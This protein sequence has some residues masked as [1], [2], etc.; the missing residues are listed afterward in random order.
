MHWATFWGIFPQT[1][2]ATLI[3]TSTPPPPPT[4]VFRKILS[5]LPK[6]GFLARLTCDR[7]LV[8]IMLNETS[9]EK[10]DPTGKS[11]NSDTNHDNTWEQSY[12]CGKN[13]IKYAAIL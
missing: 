3:V 5:L 13:L 10:M 8:L 9:D 4:H 6:K 2:L 1:H 12:D 7:S 11:S